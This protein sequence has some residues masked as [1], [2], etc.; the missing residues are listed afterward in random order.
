MP[1]LMP[2]AN[3]TVRE[4]YVENISLHDGENNHNNFQELKNE[5][6]K[7][8]FYKKRRNIFFTKNNSDEKDV[9]GM[10]LDES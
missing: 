5:K 1:Y 7:D 3:K 6:L 10:S 2:N 9:R 8:Q 4:N